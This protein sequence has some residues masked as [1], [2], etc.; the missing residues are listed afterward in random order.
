MYAFILFLYII[1]QVLSLPIISY[2]LG[3][4]SIIILLFTLGKA[5]RLFQT[6]GLIFL[7]LGL[8]A[9]FSQGLYSLE[10]LTYFSSLLGLLALLFVLPF[11]NAII[12]LGRYDK[13]LSRMIGMKTEDAGALYKKTSFA[14]YVLTIFL[15]VAT[16]PVIISSVRDKVKDFG[17]TFTQVFFTHGILRPYALVLFWSPTEILLA[18]TLD[19]TG[20]SYLWLLPVL[21]VNSLLFLYIDWRLHQRKWNRYTLRQEETKK[22]PESLSPIKKKGFEM[23]LAVLA[24]IMIVLTGNQWIDLGFLFI[25]T[26]TIIPFSFAWSIAI[27]KPKAYS[28]LGY[29][30]AKNNKDK[31]HGMF[32]LFLSAGFFVELMPYTSPFAYINTIVQYVY[33]TDMYFLLFLLIGM[34]IFGLAFIGFHPLVTIALLIP[35]IDPFVDELSFGLTLTIVSSA[36]CTMMIGPFNVTPAVLGMYINLNPY[37]VSLKNILFAFLFMVWNISA[38]YGI[39]KLL[40]VV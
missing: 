5:G 36:V 16:V 14:T 17:E 23:G 10:L 8:I 30:M 9:V 39:T 2:F 40:E 29:L 1:N 6:V 22:D 12:K 18:M 20:Q 7:G 35:F 32:F 15:N 25:V 3:I 11:M 31:L 26:V 28:R 13:T 21:W 33:E 37:Q 38:A 27:K 24:F 34:F 19:I 4:L